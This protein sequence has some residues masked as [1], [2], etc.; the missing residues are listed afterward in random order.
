LELPVVDTPL[1]T[2]EQT[3]FLPFKHISKSAQV[4]HIWAMTAHIIYTAIDENLPI[5]LSEKAIEEVIRGDIGFNGVL[6][7]DDLDMKALDDYGEI[8][9]KCNKALKAGCDLALYCWGEIDQMQKIAQTCPQIRDD[10]LE[11][12]QKWQEPATIAA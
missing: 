7:C 1:N 6:L 12:L 2:L 3:D 10:S 9:E 5:S 4:Q 11:R 8:D